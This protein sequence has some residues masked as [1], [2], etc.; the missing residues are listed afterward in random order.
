LLFALA[1]G[2]A[3]QR[4]ILTYPHLEPLTGRPR[5]TSTFLVHLAEALEGRRMNPSEIK[6]SSWHRWIQTSL[7]RPAEDTDALDEEEYH[8]A[9]MDEDC[10]SAIECLEQ[11]SPVFSAARKAYAARRITSKLTQY[12]GALSSEQARALLRRRFLPALAMLSPTVLEEYARCPFRCYLDNILA[13]K[14]LQEPEQA[15]TFPS[16]ERGVL[17]HRI[18]RDFYQW[19]LD[20]NGIPLLPSRISAYKKI[21][22]RVVERWCAWQEARG[23]TGH[24][25][26][27]GLA[28]ERLQMEMEE[29]IHEELVGSRSF[30][31][32]YLEV[33]FPPRPHDH[34]YDDLDL[35][36]LNLQIDAQTIV[37]LQGRVDRIDLAE[38]GLSARVVDY[39]SG[40]RGFKP[41]D[42]QGGRQIQLPVYA[43]AARR[44]LASMGVQDVEAQ[45]YYIGS[46]GKFWR[47]ELSSDKIRAMEVKLREIVAIIVQGILSG[48]FI[49]AGD[50]ET[51]KN[52]DCKAACGSIRWAAFSRKKN[53]PAL[54][55]FHRL[56]D[57][58]T[59]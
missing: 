40:K 11:L 25:M 50:E 13:L 27:W 18:L 14:P 55:P 23:P 37:A 5:Q 35:S 17:I 19:T 41:D 21:M 49:P 31:P 6:G 24:Q 4:L 7:Q 10:E 46:Q 33:G 43:L 32:R 45:Y 36:P 15:L 39:K 3:R 9:R 38:D 53:D 34:A 29:F 1:V 12:D 30:R 20:R 54:E 8:L 56:R 26:A 16:R 59:S 57:T 44:M 48:L 2:S 22:R 52:C 28:R 58:R 51:C 42:F 47:S